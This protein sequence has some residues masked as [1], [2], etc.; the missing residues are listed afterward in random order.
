MRTRLVFWI[1]IVAMAATVMGFSPLMHA[2][3]GPSPVAMVGN[4]LP[5]VTLAKPAYDE[6]R[7]F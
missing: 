3:E 6:G 7:A 1:T 5:C 4:V 2:L